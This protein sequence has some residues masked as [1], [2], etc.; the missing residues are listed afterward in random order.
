MDEAHRARW[1]VA[2][3][4]SHAHGRRTSREGWADPMARVTFVVPRFFGQR[5]TCLCVTKARP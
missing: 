1:I 3:F 5:V 2:V 4:G